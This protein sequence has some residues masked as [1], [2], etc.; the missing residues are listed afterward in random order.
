MRSRSSDVSSRGLAKAKERAKLDAAGKPP[1]RFNDLGHTYASANIA[2]G[3]DVVSLSKQLGHTDPSVTLDIYADLFEAFPSP[4]SRLVHRSGETGFF[5]LQTERV[6]FEP[7]RQF[8]PPTR[9]PVVHLKPL[10]HLST[11]LLA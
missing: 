10:G 9:F 11:A 3:V 6:G 2:A 8:D 5:A 7:T 4:A 1:L